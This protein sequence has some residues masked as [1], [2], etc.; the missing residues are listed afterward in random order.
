MRTYKVFTILF[1]AGLLAASCELQ[2]PMLPATGYSQFYVETEQPSSSDPGTKTFADENGMVLW[3]NGD[4]VSVFNKKSYATKYRYDGGTGTTGGVLTEIPDSG[5]ATGTNVSHYYAVYPHETYNGL[6]NNENVISKIRNEQTW[7]YC[8]FGSGDNLMVAV[9]DDNKFQFKNVGGYIVL[10]LYGEG[11][12]SSITLQGNNNEILAGD[13]KVTASIGG[14][15]TVAMQKGSRYTTYKSVTLECADPVELTGSSK[16]NPVEFWFVIP[17]TTFTQGLSFVVTDPDGNTFEK[18]TSNEIVVQ[19]S[20]SK[21][22]KTQV[23][24][25]ASMKVAFADANFKAYCVENFDRD[26]DGEIS[27]EEAQAVTTIN[28]NTEN[29]ASLKGIEQFENLQNLT[30]TPNFKK[31]SSGSNGWHLYNSNGEEVIGLLTTLDLSKNTKLKTLNCDGN[32]LTSLDVSGATALNTLYCYFNQLSSLDV[33]HNTTLRTLYCYY[34]RLTTL[35]VSSNPALTLLWCESNQLTSLDVSHNTALKEL[36]CYSNQ[37]TSLDVSGNPALTDL[38]CHFNQ[39]TSLDVSHNTALKELRC[40]S[41]QLTSLDVSGNPSLT[42]LECDDN[43]ITS[44]DVSSNTAL[45]SLSCDGNQLPSLDL[46]QNTALTYLS[47]GSDQLTS[48]D[49]SQNTALTFLDCAA[50]QLSSLDVSQN[51]T[52]TLLWC[53]GNQLTSLDVSHNSALTSLGCNSNR[54]T[55]LDVSQNTALNKLV[56]SSNQL[57]SLDVSCNTALTTLDCRYNSILREI[58]LK[59][60]QTISTFNYDSN[61]A[62]I[63]YKE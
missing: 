8:S 38:D 16:D 13:A 34:N 11:S 60:G 47:C 15:P 31:S 37:L 1:I 57:T 20:H 29:I 51:I 17:A 9:S 3:V 36:L 54:L 2:E 44:L 48:L 24:F 58:W 33:S 25:T 26:G 53:S 21:P 45:E 22:L 12:V 41:N 39:L 42:R 43:Q 62:T 56:C 50:N 10:R 49:V 52:L 40:Y 32:Q 4:L 59:T 55:S 6:D 19:R 28:V 61:V 30:C 46:S 63:K 27:L 7:D 5:S 14:E 18:S 23:D 35:D